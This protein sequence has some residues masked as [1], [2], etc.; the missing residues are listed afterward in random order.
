MAS[1]YV[2]VPLKRTWEV[3]LV[4]PLK[5]FIE[6]TYSTISPEDYSQALTDFNKLRNTTISKSV[7]KHESA[8]EV[9]YRYYDQ[10]CVVETKFPIAENQV[11]INFKWQDAFDKETL[12]SGKRTLTIS[13]G[14][15]ERVCILFN[16]AALQS[17]IAE[18]QNHSSDD[19]LKLSAKLFQQSS[20]VLSHLKE[21]VLSC[22]HADPTPDL[23]PDTLNALGALMLAQAQDC[24]V[25]K[26]MN[27]KMKPVMVAKLAMQCSDLYADALKLLQ[28]E[29]IKSLWPKDWVNAAAGKQAAQH[30]IAEFYQS[31][32]AK[33]GKEFG[34]EIARLRHAK[35]LM[36]AAESRG[37]A[38]FL[39]GDIQKRIVRALQ[40]AEK[41]NDFIYHAR[42]PEVT[43][44]TQIT[45]AVVAKS[46]PLTTPMYPQFKDLF[47][48]V[49]PLAVQ[50][51][52][53]MF[54]NRKAE[55][56]N[57]EVGRLREATTLLNSVLAS[58]N[59][60]AAIE[61]LSGGGGVP[62]SVLEKAANVR[63]MG[64]FSCLTQLINDLPALLIRNKEILDESMRQLDEEQQSDQQLRG[65]FGEHWSRTPSERL[66]ESIRSEG[67]RYRQ[68]IDNAVNAD[69]IVRERYTQHKDGIELLSRSD[70]DLE[71]AI[72]SSKPTASL[73]GLPAVAELRQLMQQVETI[74]TERDR[75]EEQIKNAT[76]DMAP[77]FV[78]ALKEEGSIDEERIS[79]E[80]L[81]EKY[82]R[83][84]E[85]VSESVQQQESVLGRVQTANME[86]LQAA[87]QSQSAAVR[88]QKLKELA[89]AYDSFTELKNNLEEG[90]KFYNDL[91][92][93]LVKFQNKVSDFCFARKTEKDELMKDLSANIA[94][95][96]SAAP[97]AAPNYQSP[98]A[99]PAP[100]PAGRSAPPP[101]PPPTYG[102]H[103]PAAQYAGAPPYGGM[104]YPVTP[105]YV[106]PA[107]PGGYNPYYQQPA[108]QPQPGGYPAYPA[109][110]YPAPAQQPGYPGGYPYPPQQQQPPY[111]QQPYAPGYG[112]Q[113]PPQQYPR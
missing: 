86:F 5:T 34:E 63:G 61:D 78:R 48:R 10:L 15:F 52:M 90:T 54:E 100:Q 71:N 101:V 35:E 38:T 112:Q 55:I 105:A 59:L 37:G 69:G 7:D 23:H 103:A 17:Q 51:A 56:I 77:K 21:I 107:M 108:Q 32:L 70:R 92:Q 2:A 74:K 24:I 25:R 30:A 111:G 41:D 87:G 22:V 8:L 3:D 89:A 64:G 13:S 65:Q 109:A 83:L 75:I 67:A 82:S 26:A 4:K 68:I 98:A 28:L 18:A 49:V 43:S 102:Q 97:P 20:G 57:M 80:Q 6:N 91:T 19:G 62:Q 9:L 81:S 66:T 113:Y 94:R 42:V 44:L 47:E 72:P 104:P 16:I 58:L 11:R 45:K 12:F 95:Q 99:P 40:D 73:Q 53:T 39:F 96:P 29:T 36:S 76:F 93:L 60:P 110:G 106:A 1:I 46:T 84:R 50:Q 14:S 79:T 88:D 85:Q 31:M 33:D 27:D